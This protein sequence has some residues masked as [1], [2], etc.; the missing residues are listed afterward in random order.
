MH[1]TSTDR[2][3][4]GLDRLLVFV[5]GV[6]ALLVVAP[7]VLGLVGIDVGQ[8]PAAGPTAGDEH[9]L[10]VLE[11]RGTAVDGGS[12]GAVR[13]VVTPAPNREPVDLGDGMAIWVADR[14]YY[15]VPD[16]A[17]ADLEGTYRAAVIDGEGQLLER[18]TDR[19]ELVFDLGTTDDVPGIPE[20]GSRLEAGETVSV[21]LVTPDGET[22][23]RKLTVPETVS[24]ETVPL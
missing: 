18:A 2:G 16:G 6:V 24:G 21:T 3:Q 10:L 22:L 4:S 19:G 13:L 23:T 14:S 5:V 1:A 8:G 17:D 15:L 20:F 11:A 9:D 12:V 7:H